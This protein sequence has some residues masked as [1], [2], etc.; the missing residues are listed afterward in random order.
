MTSKIR[1][2][3]PFSAMRG[4]LLLALVAGAVFV[5]AQAPVRFVGAI[6]AI[7]GST[8]TV[9]TDS[10]GAHQFEV[11]ATAVI[12]RIA[13]GQKDLSTAEAIP[14][15]ELEV[16]D[17]ALVKLDPNAPAGTPQALQIIAIKQ[18]DVAL[19]Q[20]R[21]REDWQGRGLGGLVKSVDAATGSILLTSGAGAAAKTIT[22]HTTKATMLKRYAPASVR[23]DDAQPA[24]LDAI[25]VG[26]QLRARGVTNAD[27][28]QIDAEEVVS[29]SF[30][31]ISGTIVSTDSS[32]STLIVKD[33][34]TK[35]P[36]TIHIGADAQLRRLPDNMASMLAARLKA[37]ADAPHR[38]AVSAAS[39][40]N[41]GGNGSS[42]PQQMLSR[43]SAIQL[44]DLKKGEAV[45]LV[46]TEGSAEVTA[47]TLV[48]GVE[49]LLEA[50]AASNLLANWSMGGGGGADAAQ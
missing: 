28:T 40:G 5:Q 32:S 22:V 41:G 46:S 37:P 39:S 43:A 1:I 8:L 21:D 17:R 4:F 19:K 42:D 33:L 26:D 7:N 34:L 11:P 24:P 10:D 29:G 48:A 2:R 18:A 20:Q 25:H 16:G 44:S 30:R 13:P 50:P 23:F 31:N 15:S 27:G 3:F 36:V 38:A 14:F 45:M 9:K 49:S 35:N 6:T 12:K 47:I